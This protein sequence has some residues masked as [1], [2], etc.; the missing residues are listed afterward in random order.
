MRF[1]GFFWGVLGEKPR[2]I[3]CQRVVILLVRGLSSIVTG[4]SELFI[5]CH[6]IFRGGQKVV[7]SAGQWGV[8]AMVNT[9]SHHSHPGSIH[10]QPTV[11][12]TTMEKQRLRQ[13]VNNEKQPTNDHKQYETIKNN[14]QTT[15]N[16]TRAIPPAAPL[17]VV[18]EGFGKTCPG[19]FDGSPYTAPDLCGILSRPGFWVLRHPC[20][21]LGPLDLTKGV[22]KFK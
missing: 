22:A 7:Q 2:S 21:E 18:L 14:D 8:N 15:Q 9:T 19:G 5:H 3:G 11:N 13:G 20:S 10:G 12:A 17:L 1:P 6:W 4:L 16:N